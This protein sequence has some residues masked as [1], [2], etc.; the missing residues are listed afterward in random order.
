MSDWV[1]ALR[2]AKNEQMYQETPRLFDSYNMSNVKS[3]GPVKTETKDKKD[4]KP[5]TLLVVDSFGNPT[6]RS[7]STRS[8][9]DKGEGKKIKTRKFKPLLD[10][11][12]VLNGH[13]CE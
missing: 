9:H 4:K 7:T 11:K 13:S 10:M 12:D 6:L 2:I 8:T 3:A 5:K 1:H